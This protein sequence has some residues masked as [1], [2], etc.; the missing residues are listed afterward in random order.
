MRYYAAWGH[1]EF[2]LCLGYKGDVISEYFLSHNEA[3][4]ND[5]VLDGTGRRLEVEMLQARRRRL[6]DHVRGHGNAV[7]DRRAAQARRAVP[8]G[9]RRVHRDVRRRLH[10]RAD[11]RMVDAFERRAG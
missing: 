11:H 10:G 9:R 3:L 1:T 2:I 5:F 4:F 6:A 7:D 8:G